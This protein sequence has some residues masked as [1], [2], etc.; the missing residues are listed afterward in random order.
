MQGNYHP[1]FGRT[2]SKPHA[3][4]DSFPHNSTASIEGPK[5][6]R[7]RMNADRNANQPENGFP[8]N[9]DSGMREKGNLSTK[10][11]NGDFPLDKHPGGHPATISKNE[12]P[13]ILG[14]AEHYRGI[15]GK[16]IP[17]TYEAGLS[18]PSDPEAERLIAERHR[19]NPDLGKTLW[20]RIGRQIVNAKSAKGIRKILE[21]HAGQHAGE[22]FPGL[23][24]LILR[25]VREKKFRNLKGLKAQANFLAY[26]IAALGRVSPSRSRNICDEQR[27]KT[28]RENADARPLPE[29]ARYLAGFR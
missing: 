15:L 25:T 10:T 22:Y 24:R 4:K 5:S 12:Y 11:Q 29:W 27:R 1:G 17:S 3:K 20:E 14:R 2:R 13:Q 6:K 8:H 19:M 28:T 7:T 23:S 16:P 26:S 18:V 21:E 9:S